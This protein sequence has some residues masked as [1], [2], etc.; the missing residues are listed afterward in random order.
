MRPIATAVVRSGL[1]DETALAEM[2]RWGLPIDLIEEKE[3]IDTHEGVVQVIQDALESLEQVRMQD[4]DLDIVK[5]FISNDHRREGQLHLRENDQKGRAKTFFCRTHMGDFVFPWR[6]ES[7]FD[8]M[9]NGETFFSWTDDEGQK[10]K[11]YFSSAR[12]LFVG[13]HK[14]FMVCTPVGL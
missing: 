14:A 9:T 1:V 8:M 5:R 6:A 10:Q 11:T 4:T 13:E 2:Q 3:V 7:I 12:E